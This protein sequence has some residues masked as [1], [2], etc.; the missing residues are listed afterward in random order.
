MSKIL[1]NLFGS[2][3]K[4]RMLRFFL[5]NPERD[6]SVAEVAKKNMLKVSEVRKEIKNLKKIKFVNERNRKR[7]KFYYL[8]PG[9][10][11]KSELKSLVAKSNAYP[12]CNIL[13]KIKSVG[14]VKLAVVSGVF[15]DCPKSKADMIL[16]VDSVNRRKLA[17]LIS[18]I[19][20]EIGKEVRY[21][22]MT[23]DELKYRVNMMDRFILDFIK[24]PHDKIIDK[25]KIKDFNF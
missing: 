17:K 15:L 13:K 8:N 4:A 24:G 3:L 7:R 14:N 12:Q 20:A 9:F 25:I 5:L 11:F 23:S 16:A 1:E 18:S 19:E 22:L 6:Y 21:V 10:I 2:R